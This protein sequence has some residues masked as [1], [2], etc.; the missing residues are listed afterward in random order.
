MVYGLYGELQSKMVSNLLEDAKRLLISCN[1]VPLCSLWSL[2]HAP[3]AND[4][5]P[6]DLLALR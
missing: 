6:P 5:S 4:R 1:G 2:H 3:A